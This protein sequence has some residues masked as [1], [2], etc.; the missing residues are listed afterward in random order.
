M[1]LDK[2]ELKNFRC[3]E[4]A[5]FD[6][7]TDIV[8]IYGNNGSGKT[9]IIEA[10]HYLCYLSSFRSRLPAEMVNFE[11]DN[12][13][14]KGLVRQDETETHDIQV[15]FAGKKKVAKIDN[16]SI[17][18]YKELFP[19]YQV[20]TV[21]VDDI[22]LIQGSPI[23]RRNFIDQVVLLENPDYMELLKR[24]KQVLQQRNAMFAKQFNYDL[25]VIWTRQLWECTRAI[26]EKRIEALQRL[27]VKVAKL[28][29][30][31]FDENYTL[32]IIYSYK[33]II[34][35][36]TFEQFLERKK[37]IIAYE[38][39][40]KRS[41]FGAHLDDFTLH[42]CRKKLKSY[43]SRGQQKLLVLL[44]KIAQILDLHEKNIHPIFVLDDFITD[45]DKDR[46]QGIISLLL[47]LDCQLIISCP[48][49]EK[50][51]EELVSASNIS[52]IE[53]NSI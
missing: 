25:Y 40:A 51:L 36:E 19:Y 21:T 30:D 39:M 22:E 12:F 31:F 37:G 3:F 43:G 41:D 48:I 42:F 7:A 10:I 33:H 44:I 32:D 18:S 5:S 35:D 46:L 50:L 47:T 11:K 45:F 49:R 8:I 28:L 29:V 34:A 20:V 17:S 38:S 15:G 4:K 2:I 14:I 24:F 6:L 1:R 9:T 13:F 23:I 53:L 27:S 16:V 26:Q 52:T